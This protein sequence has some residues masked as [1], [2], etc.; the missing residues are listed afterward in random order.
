MEYVDSNFEQL[1]AEYAKLWEM[2]SDGEPTDSETKDEE[3]P[4]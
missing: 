4:D 1:R 3:S 2:N